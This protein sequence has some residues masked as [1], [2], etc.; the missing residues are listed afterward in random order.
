MRALGREGAYDW[1]LTFPA[2]AQAVSVR[3]GD[4]ALLGLEQSACLVDG[5]PLGV[6]HAGQRVGVTSPEQAALSGAALAYTSSAYGVRLRPG[7]AEWTETGDV[8]RVRLVRAASAAPAFAFDLPGVPSLT[9]RIHARDVLRAIGGADGDARLVLTATLTN[10]GTHTETLD[11][12]IDSQPP[13]GSVTASR[14]GPYLYLTYA[15]LSPDVTHFRL[16]GPDGAAQ[17]LTRPEGERGPIGVIGGVVLGDVTAVYAVDE[18]GNVSADLLSRR[19][20]V[21]VPEAGEGAALL[22]P[23]PLPPYLRPDAPV[24]GALL[25]AF[26]AALD[27]GQDRAGEAL[28]LTQARGEALDQLGAYYGVT[29]RTGETDASLTARVQAR[30]AA[31]KS[32][33]AGLMLQLAEADGGAVEVADAQTHSAGAR[34]LDGTWRLDGSVNLGGG[35]GAAD[36]GPGEVNV[37]FPRAPLAGWFNAGAV[38]RRRKAAGVIPYVRYQV[39]THAILGLSLRHDL[40]LSLDSA[41][42]APLGRLS[43]TRYDSTLTLDGTWQ[44]DGTEQIDGARESVTE[45]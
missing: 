33:R 28:S 40:T 39:A 16:T 15:G 43:G 8:Y 14:A 27:I 22:A 45:I 13:V 11:L 36:V 31:G 41:P 4:G 29:R 6:R 9:A 7:D 21:N 1:P 24:L 37:T 25:T 3:V 42:A 17:T 35:Y 19:V 23:W 12:R 20:T 44:L 30:F 34:Q 18:A 38:V 26:E 32:S 5:V 10:G 2:P